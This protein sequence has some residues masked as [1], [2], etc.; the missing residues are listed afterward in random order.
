MRAGVDFLKQLV[1]AYPE[2]PLYLAIDNV[3]M[4]DAKVVRQYLATQPRVQVLWL[5]TYAAHEVNPIER[6]WGLIRPLWPPIV[7]RAAWRS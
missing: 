7:W 3:Q 6:I 2:G 5:P 4:H 1:A